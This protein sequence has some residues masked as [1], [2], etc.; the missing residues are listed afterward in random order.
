MAVIRLAFAYVCLFL[1]SFSSVKKIVFCSTD[2]LPI[3][4]NR[5]DMDRDFPESFICSS[6]WIQRQSRGI[7]FR[8][9]GPTFI[10]LMLLLCGDVELCPGPT[11][12]CCSCAKAV[13]KNQSRATCVQC[14]EKL[15]LKCLSND[16]NEARCLSCL[17]KHDLEIPNEVADIRNTTNDENADTQ[18]VLPELAE[19]QDKP[20]LK[21]LH[22]NIR[23]LLSHKH[24]ICHLLESF[25]NINILSLSE[26]HLSK[27]D[28]TQAIISGYDFIAK[29][30]LLNPDKG[31]GVGLYIPSHIPYQRR[32][33]LEQPEIEC[34]WLEI[35]FPKTKG[36][37]T[38][39][40]YRPPDTSKYLP[41]NYVA[42][43]KTMLDIIST[44]N[45][46]NLIL[47]DLN[48]NYQDKT[49]HKELKDL[50]YSF[51]MK[52]LITAPTRVTK[53]S[54]TLI[55]VILSNEPQNICSP[56]VIPAGLSDHDMIACVRKLHNIKQ[57]P[58]EIYCRNYSRYNPE[59]FCEDLES[60]NF[61]QIISAA[62][63]NTAL[64]L[65]NAILTQCIDKHAPFVKKRIKGRLCPW[66]SNELKQ[67]MNIRD[68]LLRRAR[69]TNTELDWSTYKRSRNK[70]NNLVKTNKARYNKELL[71]ENADSPEKFWSAIK[72]IYPTKD[73]SMTTTSMI[74]VNGQKTTDISGIAN[75]F[76][77]HFATVANTLKAKT[78]LLRNF[79]WMPQKSFSSL[80]EKHFR[81]QKVNPIQ[82]YNELKHLKRKKAV[83]VDKFPSG[84]IKDAASVLARPLTLLINMSIETGLVPSDWKIAKVI[85]KRIICSST[86]NLVFAPSAQPN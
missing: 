46:E 54:S 72:T 27:E 42:K 62:S 73:T 59:S 9:D 51:G 79:T 53:L 55:D 81:F 17:S 3:M 18:Y 80:E 71:R 20:G 65:F 8:P 58:K 33:D 49:D 15:H 14:Q 41:E 61:D 12:K 34:I 24:N 78:L 4:L 5:L 48:C 39:I 16:L 2:S 36:I 35:L 26:T 47:G 13:R 66:L 7:Q 77:I 40:I 28:E 43:F 32:F 60:Q 6:L 31:G 11:I 76:S 52:Q 37:L 84:M 85:P 86:F 30:R 23:G 38:G 22:Q 10:H 21:I 29:P 50:L 44:E 19:L 64:K 70:V 68:Q 56:S 69:R 75:A 57:K 45:K 74:E 1:W 25:K 67:E 63:V 82:V 83:G